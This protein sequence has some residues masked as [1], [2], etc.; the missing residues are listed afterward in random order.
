MKVEKGACLVMSPVHLGV[1][2]ADTGHPRMQSWSFTR[3]FGK[4]AQV[5]S[6]AH[7][8]KILC[9][10]ILLKHPIGL[11]LIIIRYDLYK[12]NILK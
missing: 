2:G 9:V 1:L 5:I 4:I 8:E 3:N 11:L 10:Q 7:T 6:L 12:K